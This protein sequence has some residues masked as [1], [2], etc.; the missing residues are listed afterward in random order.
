MK[1]RILS[2]ILAAALSLTVFAGCGGGNADTT[3][4]A[5]NKDTYVIG[6]DPE[7]PPMGFKDD[8][9][10]IIGFDIDLGD[11]VA[12]E[13]GVTFKYQPIDWASKEMELDTGSIDMIWNGFTKTPEREEGMTLTKAY[14]DNAQVIVVPADSSINKKDDL[15]GKN[16]CLQK[17]SSAKDALDK[18][19]IASKVGSVSELS[20][21][22]DCFQDIEMGRTEAMVVDKVVAKYYTSLETNEGKFRILEDELSEEEYVIAVKKGNDELKDKVEEAI[23]KVI[24]NGKGA[25]ISEK[26]FG[27]DIISFDE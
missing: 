10:N 20:S 27:E 21:N 11:A 16:I 14:L 25:E 17:D 24:D 6:L 19:E 15:E 2:V 26:W 22:V 8:S 4:D 13:M 18:D 12:E 23:Q 1:K 5:A 7:F 3:G 9:G